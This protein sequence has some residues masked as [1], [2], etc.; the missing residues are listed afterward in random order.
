MN[1]EHTSPTKLAFVESLSLSIDDQKFFSDHGVKL[2]GSILILGGL[3]LVKNLFGGAIEIGDR[4]VLNSDNDGSNTPIPTPVKFV[5]G[6]NATIK[7]GKNCDLNGVA[8]TAYKSVSI[9]DRVQI[10]AL[11]LITDT[12]FHPIDSEERRKQVTGEPYSLESV[13][14]S[15]VTIEDDV[16]IGY[17]VILLKGIT[18]G[19]GS[20]IGA[21][22]VVT[23]DVPAGS[24][25]AG[26]PAREIRKI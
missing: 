23:T 15:P 21:G 25:F 18:I 22:S 12:D 11:S 7:I 19:K 26:N 13:K 16:W 1:N 10:G 17:N 4:C 3:P 5:V 24:I 20:I 2:A 14:K 9:G 8:I 6:K